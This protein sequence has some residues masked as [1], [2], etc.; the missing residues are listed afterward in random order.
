MPFRILLEIFDFRIMISEEIMNINSKAFSLFLEIY[1]K[2]SSF[3]D[4]FLKILK[5]E[6]LGFLMIMNGI[7]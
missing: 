1:H 7:K 3:Y 4:K 6:R 5:M 2:N